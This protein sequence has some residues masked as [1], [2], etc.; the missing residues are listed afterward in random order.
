MGGPVISLLFIGL[1]IF[2]VGLLLLGVWLF[3]RWRK[4][5]RAGR[6]PT[7][8]GC[9]F[10]LRGLVLSGA[11]GLKADAESVTDAG[12]LRTSAQLC[13]ECGSTLVGKSIAMGDPRRSPFTLIVALL[14]LLLASGI[15]ALTAR[16]IWP[17]LTNRLP[18]PI[19]VLQSA[20][21]RND[22]IGTISE[23]ASRM[24]TTRMSA[25]QASTLV[26]RALDQQKNALV[27]NP[28][29]GQLVENA[30]DAGLISQEQW[31]QYLTVGATPFVDVSSKLA[32][33]DPLSIYVGVKNC[34]VS[35]RGSS[36]A[37]VSMGVT[38]QI[39]G[40]DLIQNRQGGGNFGLSHGGAAWSTYT[41][42]TSNVEP[43]EHT[44]T[45]KVFAAVRSPDDDSDAPPR[46]KTEYLITRPISVAPRGTATHRMSTDPTLAEAMRKAIEVS[47]LALEDGFTAGAVRANFTVYVSGVPRGIGMDMFLRVPTGE[48]A[49]IKR[50]IGKVAIE[51]QKPGG[52]HGF[53]G[54]ADI[55]DPQPLLDALKLSGYVADVV[56]TPRIE[57]AR[58][59]PNLYEIWG[60]E[61]VI[62]SQKIK[63][64]LKDRPEAMDT[65]LEKGPP[66]AR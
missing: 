61:I 2:A 11:S 37:R 31:T 16:H 43:G 56:F 4:G 27:W 51:A 55:H 23:L 9:G 45:M 40:T 25:S 14:C 18:T 65:H 30:H 58:T 20:I 49:Y 15:F 57:V 48:G 39:G 54:G 41:A 62:P 19:L 60:E 63:I 22:S 32:Q 21:D 10:D 3:W 7:C 26:D 17:T 42:E 50:S 1:L 47:T 46:F 5:V 44:L 53:G 59:R 34:R 66:P 6:H 64:K 13:P 12:S 29:W 24:G 38:A 35:V 28:A 33:G 36:A 52:S 8:R